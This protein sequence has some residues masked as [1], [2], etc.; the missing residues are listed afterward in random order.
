M[1]SIGAMEYAYRHNHTKVTEEDMLS[2]VEW[3]D[4]CRIELSFR[5]ADELIR[6][7]TQA[8]LIDRQTREAAHSTQ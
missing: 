3:R 4:M 6:R 2:A 5:E 1:Q 8:W 7:T